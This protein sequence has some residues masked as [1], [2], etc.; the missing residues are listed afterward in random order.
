MNEAEHACLFPRF[1]ESL[2]YVKSECIGLG[3]P[4]AIGTYCTCP[5]YPRSGDSVSPLRNA[6]FREP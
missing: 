2:I 5:L 1:F 4:A 6:L 3:P